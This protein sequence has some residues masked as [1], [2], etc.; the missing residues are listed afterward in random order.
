MRLKLSEGVNSSKLRQVL[1][2]ILAVDGSDSRRLPRKVSRFVGEQ[3]IWK[4][5]MSATAILNL[6]VCLPE[7]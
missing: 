5:L 4:M 1:N 7:I 6:P 3:I 2:D